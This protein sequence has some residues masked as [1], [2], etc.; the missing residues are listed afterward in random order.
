MMR[1]ILI[2]ILFIGCSS[3]SQRQVRSIANTLPKF[4]PELIIAYERMP[5]KKSQY[6]SLAHHQ[7]NQ[8]ELFYLGVQHNNDLKSNTNRMVEKLFADFK[9]DVLL[10]E[11][12]PYSMGESP[13]WFVDEAREGLKETMIS[14]G[15][16][17]LASIRASERNIPFYGGEID[18]KELYQTL[19]TKGYTNED[20]VGFHL[21]RTIPQRVNQRKDI[22]N[23]LETKAPQYI[24]N[25]CK[26]FGIEIPTCPNLD[27]LKIWYRS[28]T[29]KE[30]G[31]EVRPSDVAPDIKSPLF[32]QQL[33]S[34]ID[35]IRN[36]FA[37]NVIEELFKKYN[38]V[39][40]VYGGAHY[41]SLKDSIDASMGSPIEVIASEK[42]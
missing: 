3:N 1:N 41:T 22:G 32:I 2:L 12:F 24:L 38:R 5:G 9:F 10:V 39:A 7:K 23:L 28:K 25:K 40:V 27:S 8:F 14:G 34:T 21:A 20:I 11:P 15:E 26:N 17:A 36:H 19:K 18:P 6:P 4:D 30:L 37:L 35:I 42:K 16:M 33:S 13:K 29:D 31:P